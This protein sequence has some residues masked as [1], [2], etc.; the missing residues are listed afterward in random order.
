MDK[1]EILLFSSIIPIL[2]K[3]TGL[4]FSGAGL[5]KMAR[6]PVA[7]LR[8]GCMVSAFACLSALLCLFRS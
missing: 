4:E 5:F 3:G 6:L 1:R 7:F 8:I 2:V